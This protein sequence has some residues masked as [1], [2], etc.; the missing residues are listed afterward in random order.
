MFL[1]T[2]TLSFCVAL[3]FLQCQGGPPSDLQRFTIRDIVDNYFNQ[4]RSNTT[5][6]QLIILFNQVKRAT[7]ATG[8]LS[9]LVDLERRIAGFRY[10]EYDAIACTQ[11]IFG[12]DEATELVERFFRDN[13]PEGTIT[14][15]ELVKTIHDVKRETQKDLNIDTAAQIK[16]DIINR[17]Y[18]RENFSE[19][20][21]TITENLDF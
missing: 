17:M 14:F 18:P 7:N 16:A 11:C 2:I 19:I 5:Y 10:K 9:S 21:T 13:H 12:D 15:D 20:V 8:E 3:Y 6:E 4:T 1:K